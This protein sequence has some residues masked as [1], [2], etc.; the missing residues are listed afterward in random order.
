MS[1]EFRLLCIFSRDLQT[2]AKIACQTFRMILQNLQTLLQGVLQMFVSFV[3]FLGR[4]ERPLLRER[5]K[6]SNFPTLLVRGP[7]AVLPWKRKGRSRC[8]FQRHDFLSVICNPSAAISLAERVEGF[9]S[10]SWFARLQT[11]AGK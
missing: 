3:S 7:Y 8:G 9:P 6:I 11:E 10:S 1:P 2:W 5:W 4:I